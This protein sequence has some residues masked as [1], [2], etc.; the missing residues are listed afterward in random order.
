VF[1]GGEPSVLPESQRGQGAPNL[2]RLGHPDDPLVK[3]HN[4]F[5]YAGELSALPGTSIGVDAVLRR[6]MEEE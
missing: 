1:A 6:M 2:V 5:G 3:L 4:D